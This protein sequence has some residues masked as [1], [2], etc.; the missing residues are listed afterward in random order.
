LAN[1]SRPQYCAYCGKE[2]M[3]DSPFCPN[4]GK[5]L[6]PQE[7]AVRA[8]STTETPAVK[9]GR[10]SE[11]TV[12]GVLLFLDGLAWMSVGLIWGVLLVFVRGGLAAGVFL[13]GII[14]GLLIWVVAGGLLLTKGWAYTLALILAAISLIVFPVG[15]ILGAICIWL[16]VKEN[17]KKA[18]GKL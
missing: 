16:L 4:C 3:L 18:Y 5:S 10:P 7:P 1:P 17:V 12:V 14:V 9:A 6:R 2:L 13:I 11:A 15:T 8:A